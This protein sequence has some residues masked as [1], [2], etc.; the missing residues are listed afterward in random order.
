MKISSLILIA[1]LAFSQSKTRDMTTMQIT[2][3]MGIGINLG[4]TLESWVTGFGN[5]EITQ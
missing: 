3:D 5:G 2:R 4:N 1:L